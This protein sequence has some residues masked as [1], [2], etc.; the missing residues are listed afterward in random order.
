MSWLHQGVQYP[1]IEAVLPDKLHPLLEAEEL[2]DVTVDRR[3]P[4]NRP[5]RLV[6]CI[7]DGGG[8]AN[9]IDNPR[10]RV[11]IFDVDDEAVNALAATVLRLLASCV[12]GDPITSMTHRSGPYDVADPS[13]APQ[14]YL[15][16]DFT[17]RG[18][19]IQ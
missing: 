10:V 16:I 6:A 13:G 14:R 12:D 11:R 15:L 3:V 19:K 5:A 9:F 17:T 4:T 8:S 1:D 2:G 7:R 18:R